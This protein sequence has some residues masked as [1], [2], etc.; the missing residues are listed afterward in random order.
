MMKRFSLLFILLLFIPYLCRSQQI[1]KRSK[2]MHWR[3]E[4]VALKRGAKPTP[5]IT[6]EEAFLNDQAL[7]IVLFEFDLEQQGEITV[8]I[9]SSKTS[10]VDPTLLAPSI[11]SNIPAEFTYKTSYSTRNKKPILTIAIIGLRRINNDKIEVPTELE[12]VLTITPSLNKTIGSTI[13]KSNS[14][15]SQGNIY[16]LAI[17]NSGLYKLDYTFLKNLGYDMNAINPKNIHIF[18]KG[19]GMLPRANNAFRE[20]DVPENAIYVNGEADSKFDVSDY[21]V[22]YGKSQTIW[23]YSNGKY[24]H[25]SNYYEETTYYFL[26]IDAMAGKRVSL[27]ADPIGI[28][29]LTVTAGDEYVVHELNKVNDYQSGA[30]LLGESFNKVTSQNFSFTIPDLITTEPIVFRSSEVAHSV[31]TPTT[32]SISNNAVPI[33]FRVC[34]SILE[35]FDQPYY[36]TVSTI[37]NSFLSGTGNL[38]INYV[39]NKNGNNEA[40]GWLD[41]FEVIARRS[42][43]QGGGQMGFRDARS[44]ASSNISQFNLST[45]QFSI[46]WDVT[47]CT[48]I[49]QINSTYNSGITSFKIATPTLHE[50]MSFVDASSNFFVPQ[51]HGAVANQNLHSAAFADLI[52][53]SH[54]DFLAQANR[55]AAHRRQHDG[56][57]VL[58]TTPQLIYNEFSSGAQDITAIRE[59][60]RMFYNK[61][62]TPADEPKY[63]LLFGDASFNYKE[64]KVY[65]EA[66]NRIY[67]NTNYVPTYESDNYYDTDSYAS[68]DYFG[69]LDDD[70][71]LWLPNTFEALDIGIGRLPVGN[72]TQAEQMVDKILRYESPEALGE[73]RNN[74]MYIADDQDYNSHLNESQQVSEFVALAHP[75]FNQNKIYLDAYKQISLGSGYAYPDATDAVNRGIQRGTLVFN[76]TGHGSSIQLAHESLLTSTRDIINWKNKNTLPV[77][78]TATCE[79]TEF[80]HIAKVSAGENVLLNTKGGGIALL[81]TTRVAYSNIN[82][83]LNTNFNK[84]N[85][86][87]K[88]ADGGSRLGDIM[89]LTKNTNARN[90]SPSSKHFILLGDPSLRLAVPKYN[91]ITTKIN[92]KNVTGANDT[93]SAL[94]KVSI[95]GLVA[96][97]QNNPLLS[98]NGEVSITIYDKPSSYST[99]ANDADSYKQSFSMQKNFVFKGIA[100]VVNG[101]FK[102]DLIIPKDIV[103]N[104]GLG[105]ISYYA[106]DKTNNVDAAGSYI[107]IV[108][109]GSDNHVVLDD[110]GPQVRLFI[111]DTSFMNGGTTHQNPILI[112]KLFDENG[113][114]TS[115][116]SIGHE[117][118]AIIDYDESHPEVLND[119]Y[120]GTLNDFQRGSLH[121]PYY[122]LSLGNHTITVK[123]WDIYNNSG[124]GRI[125]FMVVDNTQ[126]KI[127]KLMCYPNPFNPNSGSAIFSFEHNK[128]DEALEVTIDIYTSVGE[129]IRSL[130]LPASN[131]SARFNELE[132]NGENEIGSPLSSGAY[133]FKATVK[134]KDGAIAQ[135]ASRLIIVR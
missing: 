72:A 40:R 54:P 66:D 35:G 132:W 114:N 65:I 56:L 48:N 17:S 125:D 85:A 108:I 41:F 107:K 58:V 4:N 101:N 103:Y 22:F 133:I 52:I 81:T 119:F 94:Q 26:S 44:V 11:Q 105:K 87:E 116:V 28:P 59:L 96:D 91:V 14:I 63:L 89:K 43:I 68:D 69:L 122:N 61:A 32:F 97:F 20:D 70:E 64:S 45:S 46:V 115:G 135:Q 111:N 77:F 19:G 67:D 10:V 1:V 6:A 79:F 31:S 29:N 118:T 24:T 25:V 21:V 131:G 42:L 117:M 51:S 57:R 5:V 23:N 16:K 121:F 15:L 50:F 7:P 71:G 3:Y 129:K 12:V 110:K 47:D 60:L 9:K 126:L 98:F 8:E 124:T 76:Y 18:G 100:A 62:T 93:F 106:S 2:T 83:D 127:N 33:G 78:V 112:A 55:L 82:L 113:I 53:V 38:N 84:N 27:L 30:E 92:N 86:F 73:W 49:K 128:A 109:G 130:H 39:F 37:E 80:D 36:S 99:L 13:F 120:E 104:Y 34:N 88:T 90:N 95:E 123:V 74:L 75:D 102:I 134:D